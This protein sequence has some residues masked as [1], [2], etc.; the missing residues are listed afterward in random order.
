MFKKLFLL[1]FLPASFVLASG[2]SIYEQGSRATALG[3][4]FIARAD[5]P[6]A[7]FYNPAGISQL[8]GWQISVGTT[9][10][11]PQFS[12]TGPST[13][14]SK[15]YTEAKKNVFF[16]THLY[17]SYSI[18][19]WLTAGFGF[20]SPFGL[21]TEWG[22]KEHPWVGRLLTTRTELQTFYYNPVIAAKLTDNLSAAAGVSLVQANVEMEKDVF[23]TPRNLFGHSKLKANTTG[24]G[25]NLGLRYTFF[26]RLHLGAVY[27]SSV[28]LNFNDGEARFTFPTT[29][30]PIIN[31]EV[32]SLFPA[33]TKAKSKLVLPATFGLGIA[34]EATEN[35][36][37]EFNYVYMGWHT[38]DRLKVTFADPVGGEKETVS[39]RNYSDS[40]SLRFGIEYRL[41]PH[42]TLRAG[43]LW[44]YHA[45]PSAYVEP[46][47]P[48]N[49]RHNYTIGLGYRL[50][51]W[52][53]D[54]AYQILLQDD[55]NIKQSVNN[56]DGKYTGIANLYGL[57]VGY[58]F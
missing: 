26:K 52:S 56:F 10:I 43:Y 9:A 16:P 34:Y 24:F 38:Y 11:Q 7:V 23:F 31:N 54:V 55:R 37:F 47:L 17:L 32:S 1:L 8:S 49:D 53:V 5:D 29:T 40:F 25:I 27:R 30:D 57:T 21:A 13:M 36:S 2:F 33:K 42:F 6:S 44:D 14:D 19:P 46:T 15:F 45:V 39:P 35:L 12:F 3:G 20:Y 50:K 58:A 4:A 48:E 41:D 51:S 22:T 18:K 28:T